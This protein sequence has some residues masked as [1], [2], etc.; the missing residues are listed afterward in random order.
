MELGMPTLIENNSL[1]DEAALCQSLGL[2]FIEL[3]MNFP[4]YQ[5]EDI[6][7]INYMSQVIKRYGMYYTIH[8]DENMNVCDFN[9]QVA[10]AYLDTVR[11]TI[12]IA[13]CLKIPILNMHMNEG[14]HVTLPHGKVMLFEQYKEL[15]LARMREFRD[16]CQKE[17]GK[18]AVMISIENTTGYL[19][20]Q[21]EA[22]ELLLESEVFGLT[23][24]IGHSHVTHNH[25]EAFL[26]AHENRL[27]H[28]HLHDAKEKQDHLA[29]GTG[30]VDIQQRIQIAK[31]NQCH[32][33]IETKTIEALKSSISGLAR[34]L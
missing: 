10:K 7:D 22:I 20:F 24:D 4:R 8:L 30:E 11:S 2:D 18:E 23:W 34:I 12:Q 3:N 19:P 26:M 1:E 17:I 5:L 15:Y 21:Q 27:C 31:R 29:F 6:S 33:V 16:M 32:C 13:K 9:N 28:F 14:V 25:D